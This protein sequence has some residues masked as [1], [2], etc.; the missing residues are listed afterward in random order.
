MLTTGIKGSS[1]V[2]VTEANTA[3]AMGSGELQVFATP[4]LAALVEKA[5]WQSVAPELDPGCGTV[6]SRL[7]LDHTAPTPVGLTVRCDCTLTAVEGRKLTFEAT[8]S[9]DRGP[10]GH[11]VHERFIIQND[12]FQQKADAK[13]SAD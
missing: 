6:G 8:M 11:A 5:C 3:A 2:I 1:S 10:V 12:R 4:A 9:D 7:E 13:K